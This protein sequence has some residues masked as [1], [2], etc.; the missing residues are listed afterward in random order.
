[1]DALQET[2]KFALEL[3]L[4]AKET[5]IQDFNYALPQKQAN[6]MKIKLNF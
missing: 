3:I 2:D 6:G 5:A 1:M 4:C